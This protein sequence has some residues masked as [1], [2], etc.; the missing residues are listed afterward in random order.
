[1][2]EEWQCQVT[3]FSTTEAGTT[4]ASNT[5]TITGVVETFTVSYDGNTN[6]G[7]TAPVDGSSPYDDGSLVTVLGEGDLV[8]T[9]FS[10]D[11]WNTS[12]DGSGTGYAESD[13][14]TIAADT[15]LYAQWVADVPAPLVENV[16]LSSSPTGGG[17][18][19]DDL[20]CAFDL[21]G[22]TSATAWTLDGSPLA[23]LVLPMEGGAAAALLDYRG[24]AMTRRRW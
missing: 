11:D 18:V 17:D 10:F 20:S 6:T 16:V 2:G 24:T 21:T 19:G 3:P 15:T 9:G 8:K 12:D 13:T 4:E 22:S 1:M 5:L 14:F 7:G 23:T